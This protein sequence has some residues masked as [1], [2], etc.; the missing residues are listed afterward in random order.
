MRTFLH[1]SIPTFYKNMYY[2]E[3]ADAACTCQI[4]GTS[5]WW[6]I[7]TMGLPP[8]SSLFKR[9]VWIWQHWVSENLCNEVHSRFC[10]DT[11][12]TLFNSQDHI[13]QVGIS[14]HVHECQ[15]TYLGYQNTH[16]LG[17]QNT[18]IACQNT[19]MALC[20]QDEQGVTRCSMSSYQNMLRYSYRGSECALF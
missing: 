14:K 1:T 10:C 16:T 4:L 13:L 8:V 6:G 9:V 19:N 3:C 17:W 12:L 15:N 18:C 7:M 5:G 20:L 2:P 11:L